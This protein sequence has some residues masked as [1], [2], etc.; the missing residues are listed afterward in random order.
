[1][2]EHARRRH[3]GWLTGLQAV[4]VLFLCA[5]LAVGGWLGWFYLHSK[6]G[7]D[8]L[9]AQARRRITAGSHSAST[10]ATCT[11]VSGAIGELVIPGLSLVAPVV[12]GDSDT[13]LADAVGHVPAS[14]W[15]GGD[16]A[17]VFA[18]HDV[19]WFHGLGQ[20]KTGAAIEYVSACTAFTYQVQST[21]VVTE[22]TPV[23][24]TPGTLALVTCWPLDA[25]WYT[26]QRL[27]VVATE[28]GGS[29]TAP[30]VSVAST[31]PVPAPAVPAALTSVDSLATNPAPLGALSVSGSPA[32]TYSE[33]PGPLADAAVAQTVYFA[34]LRA[35]RAADVS[36]WV[37]IA[38]GVP[39]S[40]VAPLAGARVTDY[41][42]PLDTSLEVE[43]DNLAGSTLT[44]V[45]DITGTDAGEW[46]L[47]VTEGLV[48]GKLAI[49][50]WTMKPA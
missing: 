7:G 5:G 23:A 31:P 24:N 39:Q 45:I 12:Q 29:T 50:G 11:P 25:L 28:V 4:F 33:S 1:M 48:G 19:T 38:P 3:R 35:A 10:T 34:G 37:T 46:G 49:T 42:Q 9:L 13:Q 47:T 27:L 43:G 18:A 16:G 17:S 36:E 21:Q 14:A 22:G 8:Q 26:G 20:L 15:P 6:T 40:A 2:A 32:T 44:T 41:A 30:A